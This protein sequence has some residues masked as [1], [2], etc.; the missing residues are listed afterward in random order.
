MNNFI[1]TKD[2]LQIS[3]QIFRE[4]SID[5]LT[6]I[7]RRINIEQPNFTRVLLTLETFGLDRIKVEDL[8]ESIFVVYYIQTFLNDKRIHTISSGQIK[9]CF[10]SFGQFIKYF[11]QEKEDGST[12]LEQIKFLRDDLVLNFAIETLQ[13]TFG[14]IKNIP[15]EVLFSYFSLLKAIELGAEKLA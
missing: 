10:D 4:G 1:I 13:T 14:D 7:S 5:E 2:Q 12:E 8:L 6:R 15:T 3:K 11:N 9:K